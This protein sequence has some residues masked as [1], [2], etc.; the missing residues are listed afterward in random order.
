[1]SETKQN[2]EVTD[3]AD[4][5]GTAVQEVK[6]TPLQILAEKQMAEIQKLNPDFK[7]DFMNV[8]TRLKLNTKGQFLYTL[9][10]EE[11]K[12]GDEITTKLLGG[13]YMFQL[14][15][16]EENELVC[17]SVDHIAN[18]DGEACATCPHNNGQGIHPDCRIRY[19]L[20]MH[21]LMEDEDPDEV[22][23][24]NIPSTGTY[25]FADYVKLLK[26]LKKGVKDVNT[27]IYTEEK[28]GRA[29][30]SI[31]YNAIQFRRA[32]E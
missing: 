2:Y 9:S 26:K 14:W 1:M 18:V 10:G 4:Q 3:V 8:F 7:L 21:L 28:T 23:N 20:V 17:Y 32:T 25:A 27:M 30:S 6:K 19:A 13:E 29:D 22:F 12:L 24:I 11:F 5:K 16:S 31:K 15:D